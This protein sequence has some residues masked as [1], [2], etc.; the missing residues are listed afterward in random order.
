MVTQ[1]GGGGDELLLLLD[2]E[3]AAV[4]VLGSLLALED[5]LWAAVSGLVTMPVGVTTMALAGIGTAGDVWATVAG[6][7]LQAETSAEQISRGMHLARSIEITLTYLSPDR[8]MTCTSNCLVMI[9]PLTQSREY[10]YRSIQ[11]ATC[12]LFC[13]LFH[14]R[15]SY[16]QKRVYVQF[17]AYVRRQGWP[18][19]FTP[20]TT[21]L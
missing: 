19:L 10:F 2:A 18:A 21:L 12:V 17:N 3:E 11:Q 13:A 20:L 6:V 1:L 4:S 16:A 5:E 9:L 14:A 8:Y 15:M 7:L